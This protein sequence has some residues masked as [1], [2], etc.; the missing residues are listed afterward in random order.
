MTTRTVQNTV[1]NL[2]ERAKLFGARTLEST[3][4]DF[5]L[6]AN[7][8]QFTEGW[9]SWL[10]GVSEDSTLHGLGGFRQAHFENCD[11]KFFQDVCDEMG[12]R[13][14]RGASCSLDQKGA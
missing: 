4:E 11:D 2:K 1:A 6:M 8:E 10:G 3:R 14:W 12:W 9:T 13:E 5:V 7:G